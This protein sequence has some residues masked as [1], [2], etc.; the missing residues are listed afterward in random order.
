[1]TTT[2]ITV[3][4]V[5]AQLNASGPDTNNNYTVYGLTIAQTTFQAHTDYANTWVNALL[6]TDLDP[7]DSRY[8]IAKLAALDLAAMRVLVVS[9]GGALVGAYDYFLGDLRVARSGPYAAAIQRTIQGLQEDLFRQIVN[10]AP[11]VK[12]AEA[13]AA[14]EVPTYRGGL[15]NP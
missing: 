12:A 3:T 7:T 5:Q 8:S 15:M 13:A 11:A 1:V 14:E 2:Y 6:G 4:D 10:L 9:S